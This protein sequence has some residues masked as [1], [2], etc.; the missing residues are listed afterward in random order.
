MTEPLLLW[1][2]RRHRPRGPLLAVLALLLTAR[3]CAASAR[4]G[5]PSASQSL[6]VSSYG[7]DGPFNATSCAETFAE[8]DARWSFRGPNPN[9]PASPAARVPAVPYQ[10]IAALCPANCS[11]LSASS[12]SVYGSFPYHSSSSVCLAA[13]HAGIVSDPLGGGVF[14]SRFYRHSWSNSSINGSASGG[15]PSI[16]PFTSANGALS[17]GVQSMD[18]EPGW[19][20][21]P[22]NGSSWSYTVRGRGDFVM[23][24][25]EA[26]FS[27]R[28]GHLQLQLTRFDTQNTVVV[29]LTIA[30]HNA[31]HYLN[32]VHM[33]VQRIDA[34]AADLEW[35]RLPDAPFSPR[36]DIQ[37]REP[38]PSG[39]EVA[40][41][42]PVI[43]LIG[44]QTSHACG[45]WELGMCDDEVWQ[46]HVTMDDHGQPV[47]R[48]SPQPVFRLPFSTRCQ[49][50]VV[51]ATSLVLRVAQPDYYGR[52]FVLGGQLSY[53]DSTC[54]SPPVTVN[55]VWGAGV[56]W[57][58]G[59]L[60][61][62][63]LRQVDAPFSPRRFGSSCHSDAAYRAAPCYLSGGIRYTGLRR[64]SE[65]RARLAA[66]DL[67]AEVWTC[68]PNTTAP[69][70]WSCEWSLTGVGEPTWYQSLAVPSAG[71]VDGMQANVWGLILDL[72]AGDLR[73]FGG[74]KSE[75]AIQRWLNT[76]PRWAQSAFPAAIDWSEVRVNMTLLR[77]PAQLLEPRPASL[78]V[79]VLRQGQPVNASLSEA[80]LNDP[81]GMYALGSAWTSIAMPGQ[82]VFASFTTLHHQPHSIALSPAESTWFVPQAA[83]SLNTSRPH[84]RFSLLRHSHR[85]TFL[86][87][88][89][90]QTTATEYLAHTSL[91][92]GQSGST[93]FNDWMTSQRS[94]CL[95]PM[96]PSYLDALGPMR[97]G[98]QD[99]PGS[100]AN[101]FYAGGSFDVTW[102]NGLSVA[103]VD[104]FHFEPPSLDSEILLVCA[105][106]AMWM[107]AS[108]FSMR[109]CV[110]DKLRCAYPL[111]DLGGLY[112]EPELPL[113]QEVRATY[114]D[115]SGAVRSATNVDVVTLSDV[116]LSAAVQLTVYG[117][118]FFEPVRVQLAGVDCVEPALLEGGTASYNVTTASGSGGSTST[119]LVTSAYGRI[120]S[121]TLREVY[122]MALE[123]SVISGQVEE[124]T[125]VDPRVDH[126]FATIS[127]MAPAPTRIASDDCRTAPDQPL[128]LLDCPVTR[129]FNVTVCGSTA[130]TGIRER[131]AE[132]TTLLGSSTYQL[133]LS[134]TAY[135]EERSVVATE[136][137]A[138][139]LAY[140]RLTTAQ[141]IVQRRRLGLV[142]AQSP[143]LVFGQ[144]PAGSS[145]D[146]VAL[147]S[148][149]ATSVCSLCPAGSST[150]GAVGAPS[151]SLC[152]AGSFSNVSGSASCRPCSPGTFA[153]S[154]NATRCTACTP[155]SYTNASSQT[156]CE[157]CT[158]D[159]YIVYEGGAGGGGE[160]RGVAAQCRQ[161]PDAAHCRED[162]VVAA[163]A[164]SYLL[165]DQQLGTVASLPCS[166]LACTGAAVAADGSM[167]QCSA[168][169]IAST[170]S[171]ELVQ[172][173]GLSVL[174]CCAAGRWPAYVAGDP[175]QYADSTAMTSSQGRN[176]LCAVCLPLHT[177]LAG[178][179]VP[180]SSANV[181]ALLG[182]VVLAFVLV[183]LI[184]RTPHDWSG[185]AT[186]LI[187][188]NFLQLAAVFLQS[189]S[190]PQLMSLINLS[191]LGDHH[192][193]GQGSATDMGTGTS[194]G[195][196]SSD[197]QQSVGFAAVCVAPMDD[198]QRIAL[199]LA[200]P[201]IAIAMVGVLATLQL[202]LGRALTACQR[203]RREEERRRG[204]GGVDGEF[205]ANANRVAYARAE[206]VYR[207]L[208]VPSYPQTLPR[209]LPALFTPLTSPSTPRE[210]EELAD[211][212]HKPSP[213]LL[214]PSAM[215]DDPEGD[216]DQ[217]APA[218]WLL[219]LRT[220]VRLLQLSYTGLTVL[221]LSFFH[222]QDVGQYGQRVVDYPALSP[223]SA[224]Y[225][226]LMPVMT[227]VLLVV[228]CG[229][230][231]LMAVFLLVEH[232]RRAPH[233]PNRVQD[234][235]VDEFVA[236]LPLHVVPPTLFQQA[237][238]AV[239]VQLTVMFRPSCWW[240][241]PFLLAR[242]LALV[243]LLTS[244]RSSRVWLLL[245][246]LN[247]CLLSAHVQVQPYARSRDNALET[248]ALLSLSVQTSLL[249]LYP[250]PYMSTA[251]FTAF[252]AL[253]LGP[254]LPPLLVLIA[255]GWALCR[256][257]E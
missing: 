211:P 214:S 31:T 244:V 182:V 15:A 163:G 77:N 30:G 164:G 124:V 238:A 226:R 161:C 203:R 79:D 233:A 185:S 221:T 194:A 62:S 255:R 37:T 218:L 245:S 16:F 94:R 38:D 192:T 24:R 74:W 103:C 146:Y 92:G 63:W 67:S 227:V 102:A 114:T 174:Q 46:L 115:G 251:L 105:P 236:Y 224:E 90:L 99:G 1:R 69:Q 116:P 150:A 207:W 54:A 215:Q 45:L 50:A 23:Q 4:V 97:L 195:T 3:L 14:V 36:S 127:S 49:P 7:F 58:N 128:T 40:E 2:H 239:Y 145:S 149:N 121:C 139:C 18:V 151:C 71:G 165:I 91:S 169:T 13:I 134:C 220:M 41:E 20:T 219:Y 34:Q 200:S 48:W 205:P 172:R 78:M 254:L 196:G 142:S 119:A 129:L 137:C 191:L 147:S 6:P 225:G 22:S 27:P 156:R 10:A 21:V 101:N 72:R 108:I 132:L 242:R 232:R 120:I 177:S 85:T 131:A 17:N 28:S 204:G 246:A 152:P 189:D 144:C 83:S 98:P 82:Y 231:A 249:S 173:S 175:A 19:Y 51:T 100:A 89:P 230:P 198:A 250:P 84:F 9:I 87:I 162:G 39:V 223:D 95:P 11:T 217:P 253:V 130:S 201:A 158:L 125:E 26:P 199:A 70:P 106:N 234:G 180:C 118:A 235:E 168:T 256:R 42:D 29:H 133:V 109:R 80:E 140:P 171:P 96:D 138:R 56:S 33:A 241:A 252:N 213:H 53:N 157:S 190:M 25:R 110:R 159:T 208:C 107:D 61:T 12:A 248:L 59:S 93:Y 222:L 187:V 148:G 153:P 202:A 206:R 52:L 167:G 73:A 113:I 136:S 122:G 47:I 44:G 32:D 188:A 55:E 75:S 123:V 117:N 212:Q 247:Y 8:F 64:V 81:E 60:L 154:V 166:Q 112:C 193:R 181:A 257:V 237:C 178:R 240:M 197:D 86:P 104:G 216:G 179:C 43:Q 111:A 88:F 5:R 126:Q 160:E 66:A 141:L 228:V 155:N 229:F 68:W 209:I 176:V 243:A 57:S 65:G 35:T 186:L 76:R 183:Y 184:H 210:Q 135:G 170:S 143:L